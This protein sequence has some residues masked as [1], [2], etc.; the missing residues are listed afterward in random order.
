MTDDTPLVTQLRKQAKNASSILRMMAEDKSRRQSDNPEGRT[1]LYY[2]PKPEETL[3]GKAAQ[4]IASLEARV[5]ELEAGLEP[6][7]EGHAPDCPLSSIPLDLASCA[8]A[9]RTL[10]QKDKGREL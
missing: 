10:S 4:R 3:E 5:A 9:L 6:V 1:D 8:C 7:A 2:W